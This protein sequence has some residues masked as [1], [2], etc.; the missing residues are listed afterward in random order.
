MSENVASPTG[1]RILY[2]EQM[3]LN[4]QICERARRCRDP[5]FDGRFFIGVTSTGNLLPAHLSRAVARRNRTSATSLPRPAR[6]KPVSAP[7]CAAVPRLRRERRPGSAPPPRSPARFACSTKTASPRNRSKTWPPTSASARASL[8]RL[9]LK[10]LGATPVAV[11]QTRRLHFAK[12]LIDQT[13]LP[14]TQ[15][16]LASGFN[17]IRRFNDSFRTLYGRTPSICAPCRGATPP[18]RTSII[19]SAS[20]SARPSTGTACWNSSPPAP[21]PASSRRIADG[22]YRRT[23]KLQGKRG[24]IEVRLNPR[25]DALDLASIFP[26]PQR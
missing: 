7:V 15:A 9:F 13:D 19:A 20:L 3:E 24:Q 17:S 10:H 25:G 18:A 6:P 22:C 26:T 5:R 14:F 2:S 11:A 1:R 21:S 23:I 4:R 8:R 12:T 16:A